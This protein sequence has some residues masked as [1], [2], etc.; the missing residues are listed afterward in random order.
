MAKWSEMSG[1]VL[2]IKTTASADKIVK[3]ELGQHINFAIAHPIPF[4]LKEGSVLIGT[5]TEGP[6]GTLNVQVEP[7]K[8]TYRFRWIRS[9]H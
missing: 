8:R 6:D 5:A 9:P 4:H 2:F 7:L 1:G 3:I